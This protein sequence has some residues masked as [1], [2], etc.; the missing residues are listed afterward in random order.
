MHQLQLVQPSPSSSN[1][2]SFLARSK[3]FTI[4]FIAFFLLL[5]FIIFISHQRK[6]MGFHWRLSDSKSP[7]VSRILLSILAVFNNDVFWV[8]STRSPTSKSSSPF[9]NPLVT[10]PKA[11]IPMGIIV[12]FMFQSFFQFNSKVELLTFL[13]RFYSVVC[14]DSIVDNY[15]DYYYYYYYYHIL[16]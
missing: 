13:F 8:V 16:F 5:L 4:L 15:A 14:R 9:N 2:F 7:Q 11:P 6:L 3:Y 10:V 1:F 12:T